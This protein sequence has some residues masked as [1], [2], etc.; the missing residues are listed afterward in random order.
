MQ[1]EHGP[2]ILGRNPGRLPGQGGELAGDAILAA[3]GV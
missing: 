1:L 2:V 3:L